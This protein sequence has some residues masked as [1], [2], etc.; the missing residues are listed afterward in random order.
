M[1]D[2]ILS[3]NLQ[4]FSEG[5]AE[6]GE[7]SVEEV[8]DDAQQEPKT[9]VVYGK[10]V[11]D[12]IEGENGEAEGESIE[13]NKPTFDELIE[14]EYKEAFSEKMQ[15]I[16][17]N[18]IKNIKGAEDNLKELEPAL[19]ILAE[20]YGIKNINDI[21]ALTEAI[22]NDDALYEAE[23]SERGIDVETLKHI[24]AI[25]NQNKVFAEAMAE[26]ERN[27]QNAKAWQEI[28]KQAEAVKEIYPNFDIDYEMG[29]EDF[30]QLVAVGVPVKTAFEVV[31][32]DELQTKT[33]SAVANVTAKK[34]A[35]SVKANRKR[36]TEAQGSGSTVKIKRDPRSWSDEE[37]DDIY[38][39]VQNGE[40]IY[41]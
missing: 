12:D 20:K 34:V 4:H 15:N 25:E 7:G 29:N 6:E 27:T 1:S 39:R 13:D 5:A 8:V 33:M 38:T 37:R 36:E 26:Q 24:K 2:E 30:G 14:G 3:L 16:I 9:K 35:N 19:A 22:T 21:K 32:H 23:A 11:T 40:K 18:R 17:Q 31:H 41:L 28:L 10:E